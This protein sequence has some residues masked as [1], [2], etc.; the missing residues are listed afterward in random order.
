MGARAGELV[1]IDGLSVFVADDYGP[2]VSSALREGWYE[3]YERELAT[4]FLSSGDR[5]LELGTAVG[6]VAM[7]AARIVGPQNVR[8]YDANPDM[9][10]D[11]RENFARNGLGQIDARL[12]LL[13]NRRQFVPGEVEFG[14]A[15]EFWASR[16]PGVNEHGF[17]RRVSAPMRCLEDEIDA[18]GANVMIC[19]IEG[20]EVELLIGADLSKLR[21]LILETHYWAQGEAATD[22]MVRELII[23]GFSIHLEASLRG[24]LAL[25]RSA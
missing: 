11:A 18:F 24:V 19:D 12:G 7:T 9:I 23:G 8:T 17:V 21:L 13:V 15:R 6:I 3:R 25:R 16:R 1:D 5:V 2:R 20:G 4:N 14:V 10:A 22:A